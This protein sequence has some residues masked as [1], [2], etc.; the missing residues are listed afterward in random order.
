M[1]TSVSSLLRQGQWISLAVQ[2]IN[3]RKVFPTSVGKINSGRIQWCYDAF[4][5]SPVSHMYRIE[6][7]GRLG[8]KPAVWLSGGAINKS[9]IRKIPHKYDI[10]LDDL[11]VKICLDRFDWKPYQLYVSSYIPWA[12]EWIIFFEIWCVTGEWSGGGIHPR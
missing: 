3:L 4:Q 6:I 1:A 10:D 2:L 11:R 8:I 9:N 12:M 5:T 7:E